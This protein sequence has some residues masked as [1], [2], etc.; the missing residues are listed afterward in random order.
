[1]KG[2][3]EA[4]LSVGELSRQIQRQLEQGI[5]RVH[6]QGEASTVRIPSSGHC[7]FTLKDDDA[8]INAVCFRSTLAR[9]PVQPVEGMQLELRGQITAYTS[10][11]QYQILVESIREA[12]VGDLM[13]RFLELKERLRAEGLFESARKRALPRLPRRVGIVTSETGAALRDMLNV[14]GRRVR[15]MDIYLAPASV[16]GEAAPASIVAALE[17]LQIHGRAEVIICGRGG[18]SIEDLWAFNDER[19]VRAIAACAVPVISAVGHETDTTLADYAADLR[20]ATPSAAAEL[21]SAHYGELG[22]RLAQQQRNLARAMRRQIETRRARLE[23]CTRAWGLRAPRERLGLAI[24]RLDDLREGLKR[25]MQARMSE[26]GKALRDAAG[27][28]ARCAPLQRTRDARRRLDEAQRRLT[29]AGVQS[30]QPRI[31][32]A[33]TMLAMQTERLRRAQGRA[34]AGRRRELAGLAARLNASGP[35]NVLRR[36]YSI[37]TRGKREMPV[38][39]PEQV[40][41]GE[42]VRVRGAGGVWKAAVLPAGDELFDGV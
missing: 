33:R 32:A 38:T 8:A 21:V 6:V 40:K 30:W 41:V 37:V 7:Y 13:R 29:A 35:E 12:G 17:L 11:S 28:L 22:E 1:M 19:V 18:G 4:P 24:Q 23:R 34:I 42:T 26:R 16:Q 20:A 31:A 3:G 36:G 10:R 5:G 15:G 27:R 14:L 25:A 9:Q 39:G 2:A